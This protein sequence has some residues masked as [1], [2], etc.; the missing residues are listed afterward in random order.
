M[1]D[2]AQNEASLIDRLSRATGHGVAWLTLV[3][4]II[5]FVIVVMRYLFDSGLIWLQESV[6]WM[7]AMVFMLGAAYTMQCD[8]HVRVDIFYRE[9]SPGRKAW[10]NLIGVL[11]FVFPYCA[12][13]ANVSVDYALASWRVSEASRNSGGLPFPALPLLKSMLVLMPIA[14]ALQGLSLLLR[15]VR[16]I[17]GG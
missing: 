6:T 15:S 8:E 12:F 16:T 11:L 9:L 4:V 10:V 13:L 5:T 14:I 17:R 1:S 7:H 2:S 3:M